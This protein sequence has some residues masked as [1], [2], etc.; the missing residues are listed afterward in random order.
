MSIAK[1]TMK[2]LPVAFAAAVLLA[3]CGGGGG[4]GT[5]STQTTT[6]V[7]V[8]FYLSGSTVSFADASCAPTTTNTRGEFT[9][10]ASTCGAI[11]VRGGID[12]ATGLPFKGT[13]TAPA[14]STVVT[15]VTTLI[16]SLIASGKLPTQAQSTVMTALGLRT[17]PTTT[18]PLK[19]PD[20]LAQT[21]ALVQVA[22]Q[23]AE[24]FTRKTSVTSAKFEDIYAMVLK[25]V[26]TSL[27]T[28][29]TVALDAAFV[30]A[31]TQATANEASPGNA[32][33]TTAARV[34]GPTVADM[35]KAASDQ[36]GGIKAQLTATRGNATEALTMVTSK[37]NVA[38]NIKALSGLATA[39]AAELEKYNL[40]TIDP[41]TVASEVRTSVNVAGRISPPATR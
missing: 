29:A 18:D 20:A 9:I 16:Q 21:L 3:G 38:D 11:M 28:N 26:A 1:K 6:G 32:E 23:T 8:D 5:S 31:A 39:L 10:P 2:Y 24:A 35:A 34:I 13:F 7:A 37:S 27:P 33:A 15:P 22:E 12:V 40:A 25:N 4:D 36:I 19:D 14:G 41:T 30:T 17:D